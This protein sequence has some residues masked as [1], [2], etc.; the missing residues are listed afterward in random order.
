MIR[1]MHIHAKKGNN[2]VVIFL[3]FASQS[4]TIGLSGTTVTGKY[5]DFLTGEQEELS[6]SSSLTIPA[7][8]YIIYIR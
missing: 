4:T 2:E 7:N 8:G 3:N 5:T 6:S 1:Y